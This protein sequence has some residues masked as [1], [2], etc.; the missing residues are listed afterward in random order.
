[1]LPLIISARAME[2][3]CSSRTKSHRCRLDALASATPPP[4]PVHA[5]GC[6]R[7]Q[8]TRQI[9]IRVV[10]GWARGQCSGMARGLGN[11]RVLQQGADSVRRV[12]LAPHTREYGD[13]AAA[14]LL[15]QFGGKGFCAPAR[16]CGC[17]PVHMR[18]EAKTALHRDLCGQSHYS[19]QRRGLCSPASVPTG[20]LRLALCCGCPEGRRRAA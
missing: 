1:M 9:C 12:F 2:P 11:S 7:I 3:R 4:T 19:R 15:E 17:V 10:S 14:Q 13:N 5:T 16:M 8:A 18:M 6:S 20:C